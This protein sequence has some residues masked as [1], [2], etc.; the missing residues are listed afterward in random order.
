VDPHANDQLAELKTRMTR[1][2][3]SIMRMQESIEADE[4]SMRVFRMGQMKI[5]TQIFSFMAEYNE[6]ERRQKNW[7]EPKR[8][9]GADRKAD[10][11]PEKRSAGSDSE[12]DPPVN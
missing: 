10:Q 6:K 12:Q 1:A 5:N 2:E 9:L 3:E 7:S 4:N 8:P 11:T